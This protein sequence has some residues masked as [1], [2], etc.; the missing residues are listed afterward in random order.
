MSEQIKDKKTLVLKDSD[1]KNHVLTEK[2]QSFFIDINAKPLKAGKEEY[3]TNAK[4]TVLDIVSNPMAQTKKY[5]GV[6]K[7]LKGTGISKV[8]TS[9]LSSKYPGSSQKMVEMGQR[10]KK[11]LENKGKI[12]FQKT[13]G[14]STNKIMNSENNIY[15]SHRP[16]TTVNNLKLSQR[17][18]QKIRPKSK[19]R[20]DLEVRYKLKEMREKKKFKLYTGP[21][22]EL[23]TFEEKIRKV[24]KSP[25]RSID[26]IQRRNDKEHRVGSK[27]V[28]QWGKTTNL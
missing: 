9:L 16:T 3:Q 24:S 25:N 8:E 4:E 7:Q 5:P 21:S 12:S 22:N 27:K 26:V 1:L 19:P 20:K 6:T 15:N 10:M 28:N 11:M 2:G 18:E 14:I 23:K 13:G 17:T